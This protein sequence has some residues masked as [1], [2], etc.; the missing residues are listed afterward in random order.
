LE[1]NYPK[2]QIPTH[3]SLDAKLSDICIGTSAAPTVF[4]SYYFQNAYED[5]KIR[6]FNLIDGGIADTNPVSHYL[7]CALQLRRISSDFD[8]FAKDT[9]QLRAHTFF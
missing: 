7:F 1:L 4:P 6:E 9:F 5:G 3:P 8:L 2:L